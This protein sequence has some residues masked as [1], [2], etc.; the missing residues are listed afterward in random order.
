[1]FFWATWCTHCKV[2][3]PEVMA[4]AAARDVEV[5]A[6]TDE[7][8]DT[9][10]GFFT[11]FGQ[12]FPET[13]AIDK[14]RATFQAYGVSGTPTFVLVDADGVVRHYGTGYNPS[15]GLEIQGWDYRAGHPGA[16]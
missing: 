5:V 1:L 14:Y 13:V 12:P 3:L 16:G 9:L 7:D 8:M 10:K 4:F 15:K 6:I 2:A 11:Q